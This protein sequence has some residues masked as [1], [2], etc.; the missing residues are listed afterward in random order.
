MLLYLAFYLVYDVIASHYCLRDLIAVLLIIWL[1][2]QTPTLM[3][4]NLSKNWWATQRK[5][6]RNEGKKITYNQCRIIRD[7]LFL[8]Q[9]RTIFLRKLIK[10]FFIISC[11]LFHRSYDIE[12][13]TRLCISDTRN[14]PN[15]S[16]LYKCK[17]IQFRHV[18]YDQH[19]GRIFCCKFFGC[20]VS[21][22]LRNTFAQG[23]VISRGTD[24]INL[25]LIEILVPN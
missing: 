20:A 15:T 25:I 6:E 11:V 1:P 16:R 9:E 4:R 17:L 19:Y 7:L 2:R 18:Y 8:I 21:P 12:I 23:M 3:L 22:M 14:L 5:K 10:T 24:V 13:R